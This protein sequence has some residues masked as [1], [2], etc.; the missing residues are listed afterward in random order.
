VSDVAEIEK[1]NIADSLEYAYIPLAATPP[2]QSH[3]TEIHELSQAHQLPSSTCP[4]CLH[5]FPSDTTDQVPSFHIL[6]LERANLRI[7][8]L[9]QQVALMTTKATAAVDKLAD[10]EDKLKRL[11][12]GAD[13]RALDRWPTTAKEAGQGV[14]L[15]VVLEADTETNLEKTT[16]Q[17]LN[18][19]RAKRDSLMALGISPR[20]ATADGTLTASTVDKPSDT[21]TAQVLK[22]PPPPSKFPSFSSLWSGSAKKARQVATPDIIV[23]D[24][25][26]SAPVQDTNLLMIDVDNTEL[27]TALATA[28]RQATGQERDSGSTRKSSIRRIHTPRTSSSASLSPSPSRNTT[29]VNEDAITTERTLRLT[30]EA[31]LAALQSELEELSASLFEQANTM[32]AEERRA[33]ATSEARLP[34]LE[35]RAKEAEERCEIAEERVNRIGLRWEEMGVERASREGRLKTLELRVGRIERVRRMLGGGGKAPEKEGPVS[36]IRELEVVQEG[37]IG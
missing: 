15:G 37:G 4:N 30:A 31:D 24:T 26:M 17:Y 10:Y 28:S 29:K 33:R 35:A 25:T 36:V 32:V 14:G 21:A 9:E 27:P 7:A 5:H 12:T 18:V 2:A 19:H 13:L 34:L 3:K 22:P 6:E 23:A 1:G 8:E 20:P 11:S 16:T